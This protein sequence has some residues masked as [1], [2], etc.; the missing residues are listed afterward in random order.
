MSEFIAAATQPAVLPLSFMMGGVIL[1]LMIMALGFLDIEVLD[2][3]ID[4]E[5]DGV[6]GAMVTMFK[7]GSVPLTIVLGLVISFTWAFVVLAVQNLGLTGWLTAAC[8]VPAFL[9]ALGITK[10]V[11][12]PLS[13]LFKSFND[14]HAAID[15]V[16][17]QMAILL[18]DNDGSKISQ[19]EI[20]TNSSPVIVSIRAREGQHL[21]KGARV[22]LIEQDENEHFY[23]VEDMDS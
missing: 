19:A 1:Y 5:L 12:R 18:A 13:P 8:Y 23:Y 7:V 15:K 11:G 22:L 16:D 21:F 2:G 17:G 14:T 20:T 4:L 6:L 3:A 10:I 9:L